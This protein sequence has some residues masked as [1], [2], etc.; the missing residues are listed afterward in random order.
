MTNREKLK[1][2]ISHTWLTHAQI[3]P[4]IKHE[5]KYYTEQTL[6]NMLYVDKY[7]VDDSVIEQLPG[8]IEQLTKEAME[9]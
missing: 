6:R 5:D 9:N 3:A 1:K 4:H 7:T 8:I 2:L